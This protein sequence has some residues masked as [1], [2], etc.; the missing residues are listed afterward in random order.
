MEDI[1]H[2][3]TGSMP[4]Q[5]EQPAQP[6]ERDRVTG[7]KNEEASE[8]STQAAPVEETAAEGEAPLEEPEIIPESSDS[9]EGSGEEDE[10]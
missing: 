1:K 2:Q 3:A 8:E 10:E 7:A 5:P 6:E 4:A 9:P